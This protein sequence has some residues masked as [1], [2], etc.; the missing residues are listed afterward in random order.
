MSTCFSKSFFKKKFSYIPG[1]N[2]SRFT[3]RAVLHIYARNFFVF[4]TRDLSLLCEF[5][6][7]FEQFTQ[8]HKYA[9]ARLV[10]KNP[11]FQNM[12]TFTIFPKHLVC[13][14]HIGIVMHNYNNSN[15][16]IHYIQFLY[17]IHLQTCIQ[18]I[19]CMLN[20]CGY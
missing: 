10:P 14:L 9:Y 4:T 1:R 15:A 5:S 17:C 7:F 18:L 16:I 12:I 11:H 8:M 2:F 19:Y 20:V 13:N 6:R 3:T